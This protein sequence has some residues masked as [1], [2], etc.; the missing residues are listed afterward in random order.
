MRRVYRSFDT[1]LPIFKQYNIITSYF[2]VVQVKVYYINITLC[3][4]AE[5]ASISNML[6]NERC[7]AQSGSARFLTIISPKQAK[8]VSPKM[9]SSKIIS[10]NKISSKVYRCYLCYFFEQKKN[11]VAADYLNILQK[12]VACNS[13]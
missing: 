2:Q 6:S 10:S 12:Q 13:A 11:R 4:L 7:V 9:V 1:E 3:T 8:I 5:G